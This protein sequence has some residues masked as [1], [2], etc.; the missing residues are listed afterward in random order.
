MSMGEYAKAEPLYRQAMEIHKKVLGEEHP[1][2]ATSLDNLS[3]LYYGMGEYSQAEPLLRQALAIRKK[4]LGEEH[5]TS[6][7]AKW[8]LCRHFAG[9]AVRV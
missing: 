6:A 9:G 2:Y 1:D 8:H 3:S 4:V 7:E 5:L